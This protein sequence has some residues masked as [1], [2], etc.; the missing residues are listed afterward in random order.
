MCAVAVVFLVLGSKPS[1]QALLESVTDQYDAT[2]VGFRHAPN[3]NSSFNQKLAEVNKTIASL[4]ALVAQ[5]PDSWTHLERLA[6]SYLDK[7][8]L[9]GAFADYQLADQT[10]QQA[11][12][13]S[14]SDIGPFLSR[15]RVHLALHRTD[16]AID[17]LERT[18]SQLITPK[19]HGLIVNELRGDAILQ[20]GLTEEAI[21]R[22]AELD[23]RN[24]SFENAA[25][26]SQAYA[27]SENYDLAKQWLITA[28]ERMV[29]DSGYMNAWL[30][31]QH[32][33]LALEQQQL[34]DAYHYFNKADSLFPGYWLIE[35]H[36]AEVDTLSGRLDI[37]ENRY[38]DIVK[39][40]DVPQMKLALAG[41]L[42]AQDPVGYQSEIQSLRDGAEQQLLEIASI[43]PT[44]VSAH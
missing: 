32:G 39:R 38:R 4:N 7:A 2:F 12:S 30:F 29:G 9:S 5:Y 3:A 11:F 43:Y 28:E 34:D 37:A 33:I 35:E 1:T 8:R 31:L 40:S 10:I 26:L 25:R 6:L 23:S 16:A 17:D 14:E 24:P 27:A 18:K 21:N 44:F 36:M 15:A 20:A 13:I 22:F 19:G 42:D 41:V